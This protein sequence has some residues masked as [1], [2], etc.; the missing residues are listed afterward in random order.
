VISDQMAATTRAAYDLLEEIWTPAL[1]K[2]K[3]ELAQMTALLHADIPDAEFESWD[4]WYYAEK[5]RKQ[6]YQLDESLVSQYLSVDNVRNGIFFLANRLY[7]ITFRPAALPKYHQECSAYEVLDVDNSHLGVLYFDL[8]PRQGKS[9]GAWCG[10]FTEQRYDDGV[11]IAPTVGIVCNF[12]R[13]TGDTPALL[14]I[15]ETETLFHEF[16]HALHFLF[17]DVRYRGLADVEGDFVELPSQI[18]EN[19]AFEPEILKQYATHYKTGEPIP[20]SLIQKI[21]NAALFNQ[22]FATTELTAAALLD[23]DIHSMETYADFEPSDFEKYAL[24][25]RRGLIPQIEPRYRLPYFSHI[26]NGGYSSGYYFYLW[27]EVLDKDAFAAFKS[28]RDI[29]DRQL[30]E[31]FRRDLLAQGG[32][33]DGMAMYRKFRGAG[34]DKTHMLRSRGLLTEP[35]EP[36]DSLQMQIDSVNLFA[37]ERDMQVIDFN[38]M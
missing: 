2:A 25:T 1:D 3:E 19:W 18:M 27:A 16:G 28:G 13:P 11:R 24:A 34:P 15:D 21:R 17:A 29:C 7:G 37:P 38:E 14:S 36:A 26:F 5:V 22:G 20:A 33:R 30:A 8:Y 31:S 12:T 4:W 23:L 9:G 6:N 32:Q 10:Y 35:E